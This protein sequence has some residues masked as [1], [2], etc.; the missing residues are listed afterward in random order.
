MKIPVM[1]QML[2]SENGATALCMLLGYYKRFIPIE[3]M[4]EVCVY[5][6]NGSNPEHIAQ[7]AKHY[8]LDAT[9]ETLGAEDLRHKNLPVMIQWK[10][11]YYCLIQ[12]IRGD[13]VTVADPARG[14]Y[15]LTMKKLETLFTGTVISFQKNDSF[16]KGGKRQ[17]LLSLIHPRL[18]PLRRA[19]IVLF[20]FTA[21][22]VGLNLL[23]MNIEK[24]VL[25]QYMG[26]TDSVLRWEGFMFLLFYVS[27]MIVYTVFNILKTRRVNSSSRLV[28]A[29]SGSQFFKNILRKP[30]SFFEQYSA[31]ELISRIDSNITLDN[32]ILKAVVPRA[33][34]AI[35]S[36]VCIIYLFQYNAVIAGVCMCI[37]VVTILISGW[38]QQRNAIVSKSMTTSGNT[39]NASLLNGMNMIDTIQSTGSERSFYNMWYKSQSRF[40]ANR[41]TQFRYSALSNLITMFSRNLLQAVLLFMGAY[42][43]VHGNF[44]VGGMSLFQGM[45]SSMINSVSNCI[46]SVD[47]LQ[48][49]RTNI[50]RVN[51]INNQPGREPIP[52]RPEDVETADKLEGRISAR[53][54]CYRYNVGDQLALDH[55]SVEVEPGQMVAIVGSTGCGKSTLLKVLADL[56]EAESGEILYAGKHREEIPDVVFHSSISSVD[57][58]AVMFEDSIYNNIKMWDSTIENFEV[59]LAAKDAQIHER[60]SRERNDYSATIK[61]NGRNYSGGELQR[62]EL[63]RALAHEPTLLFLDEFTSALDALTEDQAMKALRAKGTTCVIVAHRL[64]TIVDCDRIYVMDQ[65]R[66]VQQGTHKELYAQE[67]LYRTLIG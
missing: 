42:F 32:S 64:S 50:E 31:Y 12:S 34:D 3:E 26:Q 66:I 44:T 46:G 1:I 21:I 4:R 55:V 2:N 18:K 58:E 8:G 14:S 11:R 47:S 62:I 28:S 48:T 19:M 13:I 65:G 52:L 35:V 63:A 16:Q 7:A 38:V 15:K 36:V 20:I 5:S 17:T 53:N 27:L 60:I 33:I 6:R 37:I 23:M 67:G 30:L 39:V 54:L 43:V 22:C 41:I 9:V 61:E 51:D 25:D 57:Q 49:M 40:N 56:Y 10:K 24:K 45:L 59:I 29:V